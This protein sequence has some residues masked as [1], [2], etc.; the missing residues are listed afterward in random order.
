[1][2]KLRSCGTAAFQFVLYPTGEFSATRVRETGSLVPSIYAEGYQDAC[3]Y[4][5]KGCA[6]PGR[7]TASFVAE[8]VSPLGLSKV[9]NSHKGRKQRGRGGIT[10]YNKRLIVNS[11]LLL[12]RKYGKQ[13]LGFLTLTL[14]PECANRSIEPYCEAKRQMLQ[15]FQR[16]LSARGLSCEVIGCTEVQTSRLRDKAQFALHEHWVFVGRLPRKT[17]AIS[18]KEIQHAWLRILGRVYEV[19]ISDE[20]NA[21]AVNVQRIKRSASSYLGK[22]LSKGQSIVEWAV[23]NGYQH[24]LP[25]SWVTRSLSMLKMYKVS[26]LKITGEQA[27]ILNELFQSFPSMYCRW[28]RHLNIEIESSFNI[29][30]AFI[31]YLNG[32]GL[33]VVNCLRS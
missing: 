2:Q 11:A 13:H 28:S 4:L 20:H 5:S 22:Y 26:I 30:I 32:N 27:S 12:E 19:V 15:W 31:G 6:S 10:S 29:W 7:P 9:P 17:W 8:R 16:A 18:A 3:D 14:P 1:M 25:S 23:E 33:K 21:A 24:C